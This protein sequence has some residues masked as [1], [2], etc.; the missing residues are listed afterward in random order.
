MSEPP[1]IGRSADQRRHPDHHGRRASRH[2]GRRDR[3]S[4][5]HASS[6]SAS[7]RRWR[8]PSGREST[9][10]ARRFVATPGFFDAHIHITGDPLTRGFARGGPDVSWSDR[11]TKWVIPI[12]RT[13]T[14]E[15]ERLAAQC[16]A[17]AMIR[18]GT[19]TL[20]R[21]RHRQ[22]PRRDHGGSGRDRHPRP[23]GRVGRGP[24]ARRLK[25]RPR[26][27]PRRSPCSNPRSPATPTTGRRGSPP[28]R[29]WSG[30]S[31]NSD[32]VWRAAKD[33]RRRA[34]PLRLGP[35]E[36][37]DRRSGVVPRQLWTPAARA[38]GRHR[39][40]GPN[41][42][43]T[44]LAQIDRASSTCWPAPAPAPSTAPH[45]AFQGGFGLSQIGL[46]PEMLSARR[47]RDAGHRRRRRPTSWP[48]RG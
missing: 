9:L 11:L 15:D 26:S 21:G 30:H 3:R 10:D 25:T 47:Q 2:R 19:T 16:A 29:C 31:T 28:G 20:P 41:V 35:H 14:P 44:H 8:A 42:A 39:R 12:F 18:Y 37:S 32:A 46:Y 7:A 38:P 33:A 48:R 1:V 27:P 22:P 34:W 17:L 5:G 43:L 23:G 13:Q 40:A 4:P 36:P 45:A 24:G 6:R